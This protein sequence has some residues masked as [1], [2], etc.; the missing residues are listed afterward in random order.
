MVT[1]QVGEFMILNASADP[2]DPPSAAQR[3]QHKIVAQRLVDPTVRHAMITEAAY[4]RAQSRGFEPNHE[5]D[6]WL[7][8]EIEVDET[9]VNAR[10]K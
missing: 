4:Y 10:L 6:D 1:C 3:V 8:A 2:S 7:E 5:L 9:L